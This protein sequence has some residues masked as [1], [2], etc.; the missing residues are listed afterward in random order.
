MIAFRN[1]EDLRQSLWATRLAAE[2]PAIVATAR[3]VIC[4]VRQ[5][6]PDDP[7]PIG[8][9]KLGG[10]PDLP[11]GFAWPQR[12]AYPDAEKRERMRR[13]IDKI[14]DEHLSSM[15]AISQRHRQELAARN[16]SKTAFYFQP[17]PLAFRAQL[18]LE[19]LSAQDGFD[20][21]LPRTGMLSIFHDIMDGDTGSPR[22]FWH[23]RPVAD[24]QRRPVPPPLV[25][26][27]NLYDE[28]HDDGDKVSAWARQT[29]A[30][31]LHPVSGV[32]VPDH[33]LD[34]YRDGTVL[35]EAFTDWHSEPKHMLDLK[36]VAR[37][38]GGNS[39]NF[40]DHLSG[41]PSN[42]QGN[43]EDELRGDDRIVEPG[44]T[45]WLHIF[46]Y[47]GEFWSGTRLMSPE[48]MGDGNTYIMMRHLDVVA[49]RFEQAEAVYQMT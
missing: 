43:P 38:L 30:E 47:G 4:F 37:Q 15:D 23:D 14:V 40:G 20:P 10:F 49:R 45:P 46:S 39:A 19:D 22:L 17:F 3:P 41:W 18:N 6:L 36:T 44:S 24:L 32:Q 42:I 27:Y 25:D 2:I 31:V 9:S 26:Y 12:P 5:Q 21:E 8:T 7:L 34:A 29:C 11:A 48:D 33:W 28:Q 1:V 16:R 35:R 13:K